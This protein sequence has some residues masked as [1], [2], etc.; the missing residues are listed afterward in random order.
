[1]WKAGCAYGEAVYSPAIRLE[2]AGVD[3]RSRI[4]ERLSL[5][6][7]SLAS[8]TAEAREGG[9]ALLY[10][11]IDGFKP[12]NDR[13]GHYIRVTCCCASSARACWQA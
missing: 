12:V 13:R 9:C 3:C 2:E 10:V 6:R 7:L 1:M 11:D 8:H 5:E 4:L